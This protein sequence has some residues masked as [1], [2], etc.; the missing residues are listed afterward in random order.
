MKTMQQCNDSKL[1]FSQFLQVGDKVDDEI[2]E[3]F[4]CVLPPETWTKEMIQ[5]GEPYDHNSE[6]RPR[7]LTI[8]NLGD[9]WEYA[10]I[11]CKPRKEIPK[12]EPISAGPSRSTRRQIRLNKAGRSYARNFKSGKTGVRYN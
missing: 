1:P 6:G 9:G 7:F 5:M 11:K 12:Q 8:V 4:L 2:M 10:G 3:Y